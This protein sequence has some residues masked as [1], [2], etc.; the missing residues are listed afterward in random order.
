MYPRR[1]FVYTLVL[2]RISCCIQHL[3]IS[4]L[5]M[6][7]CVFFFFNFLLDLLILMVLIFFLRNTLVHL[8]GNAQPRQLVYNN[9]NQTNSSLTTLVSKQIFPFYKPLL[10]LPLCHQPLNRCS[11]LSVENRVFLHPFDH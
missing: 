6:F 11:S 4:S 2:Q 10:P 1:C 3:H 5:D 7:S 8:R 9:K